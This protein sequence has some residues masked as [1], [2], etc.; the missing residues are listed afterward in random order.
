MLT[1]N[2]NDQCLID[3]KKEQ[4]QNECYLVLSEEERGK[5]FIRPYRDSY[6]HVGQ[7]FNDKP[8]LLDKKEVHNGKE[9]VAKVAA[10]KEGSK[11]I[12]YHF[13]TKK[14]YDQINSTGYK[15]GCGVVTKMGRAL[16]ETYAVNPSFY[17]ATFCV[18][19]N[20]HLPVSE[21]LWDGTDEQVGS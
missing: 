12:G 8:I 20:K 18:G 21:F 15:G 1:T 17:Q 14:D 9:Y 2:P 6:V 4:G 19:C 7:F 5:G 13:L 16:S 3:G 11:I 10:L